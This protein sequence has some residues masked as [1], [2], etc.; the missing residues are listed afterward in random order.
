LDAAIEAARTDSEKHFSEERAEDK[1]QLQRVVEDNRQSAMREFTR[2][3]EGLGLAPGIVDADEVKVFVETFSRSAEV[4]TFAEGGEVAG[5][6]ALGRLVTLFAEAAKK[7][8]L[9]GPELGMRAAVEGAE[10]SDDMVPQPVKQTP[11]ETKR[12]GE[13]VDPDT[14]LEVRFTDRVAAVKNISF[15][16]ASSLVRG[17]EIDEAGLKAL[18]AQKK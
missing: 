2:K 16:A 15:D 11:E 13:N 6:A 12:F 9:F 14:L 3:L 10:H 18:E 4:M 7:N 1:K 17:G 5:L 8:A